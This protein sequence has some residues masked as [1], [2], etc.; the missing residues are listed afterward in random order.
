MRCVSL[1]QDHLDHL[2]HEDNLDRLEQLDR[3]ALLGH[4]DQLGLADNGVR[5]AL[6]DLP[7]GP[8]PLDHP[9]QL[10]LQDQEDNAENQGLLEK[11]VRATFIKLKPG[12]LQVE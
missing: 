7:E 10:V 3:L 8:A 4:V 6:L 9:V 11:L 5:R 1:F 12:Q 2:D